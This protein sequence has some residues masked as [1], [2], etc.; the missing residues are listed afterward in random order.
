LSVITLKREAGLL[1]FRS[2]ARALFV[3]VAG[4]V[5][6][7]ILG[8]SYDFY[9]ILGSLAVDSQVTRQRVYTGAFVGVAAVIL[10]I[11]IRTL[12]RRPRKM[13]SARGPDSTRAGVLIAVATIVAAVLV[14]TWLYH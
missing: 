2:V 5:V 6:G 7:G 14:L 4:A 8:F 9:T 11:T 13:N 3:V 12:R 10:G 1:S